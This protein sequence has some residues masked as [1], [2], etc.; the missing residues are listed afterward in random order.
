MGNCFGWELGLNLILGLVDD[1]LRT[2]GLRFNFGLQFSGLAQTQ[3]LFRVPFSLISLHCFFDRYS[4][5][6]GGFVCLDVVGLGS[7]AEVGE[8]FP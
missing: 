5:P 8:E 7:F 4:V 2:V 6:M 3:I 1:G